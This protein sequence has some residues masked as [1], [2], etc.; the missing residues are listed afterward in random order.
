MHQEEIRIDTVY[1]DFVK[2]FNKVNHHILIKKMMKN[3]IKG[4][5]LSWI[6]SFLYNRKYCVVANEMISEKHDVL[7]GVT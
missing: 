4:K 7:S 1:L 6:I 2:A 5:L 3:Q